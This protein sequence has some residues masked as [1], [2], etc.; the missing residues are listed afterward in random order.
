M[1]K[2]S[3]CWPKLGKQQ[4]ES[5]KCCHITHLVSISGNSFLWLS[6]TLKNLW[7]TKN[8]FWNIYSHTLLAGCQHF[9]K[10]SSVAWNVATCCVAKSGQTSRAA[11][12]VCFWPSHGPYCYFH[13]W[14]TRSSLP[15]VL[16][17]WPGVVCA[18]EELGERA[19][20]TSQS[21]HCNSS[22]RE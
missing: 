10:K 20:E 3:G 19:P 15:P 5:W 11:S 21:Q 8:S 2:T 22:G 18:G 17:G 16:F 13:Y 1:E 12:A 7:T 9:E 4:N 6:T 14:L